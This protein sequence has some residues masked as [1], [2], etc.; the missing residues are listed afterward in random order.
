MGHLRRA[1]EYFIKHS[2]KILRRTPRRESES[3]VK[4]TP[5]QKTNTLHV[6]KMSIPE[7][8]LSKKENSKSLTLPILDSAQYA[9]ADC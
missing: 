3:A 9:E 5:V 4:E 1:S 6:P 8:T 2:P 7:G